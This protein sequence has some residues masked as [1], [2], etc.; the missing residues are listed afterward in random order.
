VIIETYILCGHSVALRSYTPNSEKIVKVMRK[1]SPV[2]WQHINFLGKYVFRDDGF[3]LD[4]DQM[5]SEIDW[6]KI[7]EAA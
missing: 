1:I 5:I 4:M 3:E 7:A 2:S 6:E